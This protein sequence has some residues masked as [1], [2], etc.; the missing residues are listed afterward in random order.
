M[1]KAVF[2]LI[3]PGRDMCAGFRRWAV[4]HGSE[5]FCYFGH[6]YDLRLARGGKG[7]NNGR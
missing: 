3:E 4:V 6:G 7:R 5:D 2:V 1:A